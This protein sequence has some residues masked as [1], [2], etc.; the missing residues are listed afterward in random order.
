MDAHQLFPLFGAALLTGGMAMANE[1]QTNEA[2]DAPV[3]E[4]TIRVLPR[5][6]TTVRAVSVIEEDQ[7]RNIQAANLGDVF[8]VDPEVS[9]GGGGIPAAQKIYVRGLEDTMLNVEINGAPQTTQIYHHQSRI[10]VDPELLKS[11]EVQSGAGAATYGPGALGGSVQF[12]YKN[13]SDMLEPGQALGAFTKGGY[14]SNGEG[15]KA[16]AAVYGSVNEALNLMAL[17]TRYDIGAYEAG[18][19]YGEVENTDVTADRIYLS[20]DG[21]LGDEHS[22]T[23]SYDWYQDEGPRRIRANFQGDIT[24]PVLPNPVVDQ[25]MTRQTAAFNY[26]FDSLSSDA[27]NLELKL[28]TTDIESSQ[29]SAEPYVTGPPFTYDMDF[30]YDLGGINYG[31][32]LR[33]TSEFE[34]AGEHGLTYGVDYRHDEVTF[35]NRTTGTNAFGAM[36]A[37]WADAEANSRVYGAYVQDNWRLNSMFLISGG[38]RWDQYEYEDHQDVE[39]DMNGFSPNV[40]LTFSPVQT[41]D[42]YAN[43]ARAV[44]GMLAP[45]ALFLSHPSHVTDPD[46]DPEVAYNYELG[47][48]F[49]TGGFSANVEG[50]YQEI[51]DYIGTLDRTNVGDVEIP[52]YS[53]SV[54]YHWDMLVA[55]IGVNEAFPEMNGEM[56]VNED[57]IGLGAASSRTWITSLEYL[58]PSQGI[59]VG[60]NGRFVERLEDLPQPGTGVRPDK[61]GFGV[62]D[63]YL[64]WTPPSHD[65]LTLT[66]TVKNVFDKFYYEHTTYGYNSSLDAT[67]GLPEPGR[68]FRIA[69]SYRF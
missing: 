9:V 34:L 5:D 36:F 68:D 45:E 65:A 44:R 54:G 42:L 62:H 11:V 35:D 63:V 37:D 23:A 48:N 22:Y 58:F 25:E 33:N 18:G 6:M 39:V 27:V 13:A 47:M 59:T 41:V 17:Y 69:A 64:S 66:F 19:D 2:A 7:V 60:W 31:A 55:S 8:R 14:Y 16:D 40:G 51:R 43:A 4:E 3:A 12:E 28:Y 49:R 61:A 52:G 57:N 38:L 15:Y 20:A 53:A 32:D 21:R 26:G 67:V 1:L 24:H 30:D 50:F 46:A 10:M 56:L 29:K